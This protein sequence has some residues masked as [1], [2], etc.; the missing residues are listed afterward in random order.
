MCTTN[1]TIA[2]AARA[3]ARMLGVRGWMLAV[4]A[5][6]GEV[7]AADSDASR[8]IRR[9]VRRGPQAYAPGGP[10]RI[11]SPRSSY[12]P[13]QSVSDSFHH[14]APAASYSRIGVFQTNGPCPDDSPP[15]TTSN[16]AL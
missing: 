12:W 15:I 3:A 1:A 14:V 9:S 13:R 6:F 2:M 7:T 5:D 16:G 10:R 11:T 4:V 8:F